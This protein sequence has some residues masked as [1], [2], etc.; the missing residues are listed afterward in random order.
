[1]ANTNIYMPM[2]QAGAQADPSRAFA[3]G[4]AMAEE[5][6]RA[7]RAEQFRAKKAELDQLNKNRR[8]NLDVEKKI[9][10]RRF[11]EIS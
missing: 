1:M 3:E 6:Q 5:R 7:L 11:R 9:L 10:T 8:F 4:R 2:I